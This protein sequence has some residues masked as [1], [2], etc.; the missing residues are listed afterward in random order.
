MLQHLPHDINSLQ[1]HQIEALRQTVALAA[2]NRGAAARGTAAAA[3]P[4]QGTAGRQA[5]MEGVGVDELRGG[6]SGAEVSGATADSWLQDYTAMPT[7][8]L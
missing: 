1:P 8:R 3:G 4:G 7:V 2:S 5:A 6:S